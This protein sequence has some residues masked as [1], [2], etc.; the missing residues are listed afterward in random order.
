MG[1]KEKQSGA[2]KPNIP[3]LRKA[4]QLQRVHRQ[5]HSCQGTLRL[6]MEIFTWHCVCVFAPLKKRIKIEPKQKKSN[7]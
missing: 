3:S 2:Y 7:F 5:L 4:I 6:F 1:I